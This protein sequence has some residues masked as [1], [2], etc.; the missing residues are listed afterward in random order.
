MKMIS[1]IGFSLLL[2]LSTVTNPYTEDKASEDVRQFVTLVD[3]SSIAKKETALKYIKQH[4]EDS[5]EIMAVEVIYFKYDTTTGFDLLDILQE[6]TGLKY[7]YDFNKWYEYL[8]NKPQVL[9]KDYHIFKSKL[10]KSIDP[11]FDYYFRD[12]QEQSLIRLDEIRWGGVVQDGIPPLRDPEMISAEE[13]TYLKDDHVVFGIAVNG[14]VRAYPKRILAWH[15][16]FTDTVGG[17]K[18]AGVYCT[19]CGTVILYKTEVDGIHHK[20]GTSGFLYRSNKLMYDEDTQSLWSTLDG[21]PVVGPLVGLGIEFDYLSVV[22]TTWGEWKQRHPNTKVLSLN[23]GHRRNY[24]EGVAY[25]DYFS[26]DELMFNVPQLSKA[27]KNKASILA[28]KFENEKPLAVAVD[29][30]KENPLYKGKHGKAS[31]LVL[32]DRSGANRVYD[33][34][35]S[36]FDHYDQDKT[37]TDTEGKQ[38]TVYE[39]RLENESGQTI[40]RLSSFNAFWFGWK[41][42]Y[43]N[44]RLIKK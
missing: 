42:A 27:L 7:G 44:T 30:L 8:W 14:D 34:S 17:E 6:K 29:F 40:S 12:R 23:T 13:A 28:L 11:R 10:H 24:G 41:A 3:Y 22:T 16:M 18:V 32:T 2:W 25:K 36:Q 26:T 5:F 4:W 20:M 15:E 9:H 38:W 35:G 39:D 31:F 43:P 33:T 1:T 21:K 19:L 37:L